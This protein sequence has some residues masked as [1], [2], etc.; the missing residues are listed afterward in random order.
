MYSKSIQS[1]NSIIGKECFSCKYFHNSML[2][3]R[4]AKCS[5]FVGKDFKSKEIQHIYANTTRNYKCKGN[6][7]KERENVT[8]FDLI[9]M[10]KNN[11]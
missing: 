2:G 9:I 6:Y 1:S 4:F 11:E 3:S 5:K 8:I 7:F 10:I